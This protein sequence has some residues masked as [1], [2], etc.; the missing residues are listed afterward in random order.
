MEILQNKLTDKDITEL[1]EF[2]YKVWG[3]VFPLVKSIVPTKLTNKSR[4]EK[5]GI[6]VDIYI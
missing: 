1:N 2:Q 3:I 4:I 6:G 5:G